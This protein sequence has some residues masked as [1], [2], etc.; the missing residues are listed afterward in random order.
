[1]PSLVGLGG[2]IKTDYSKLSTL[3]NLEAKQSMANIPIRFATIQPKMLMKTLQSG[4]NYVT[5]VINKSKDKRKVQLE[6]KSQHNPSILF[7]DRQGK[8]V[9]NVIE[10]SPEE[11]LVIVWN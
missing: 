11:T 9:N 2:R 4:N 6:N 10:I 3:L 8:I 7:A 5:V 1:M